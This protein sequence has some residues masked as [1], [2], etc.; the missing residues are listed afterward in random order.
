M[1]KI[2]VGKC[3]WVCLICLVA[4]FMSDTKAQAATPAIYQFQPAYEDGT[5]SYEDMD[6]TGDGT[7]DVIEL[8]YIEESDYE[9]ICK[10][11]V[12]GKQTF[13]EKRSEEP[14]WGE[15]PSWD[16]QLIR[17]KNGK[18]LFDIAC[19]AVDKGNTHSL[20]SYKGGKLTKIYDFQKYYKQYAPIYTVR[21]T[22]VSGNK[23]RAS[24][25]AMFFTTGGI[26]YNINFVY[27]SG[28]VKLATNRYKIQYKDTTNKWT[29]GRTIKVYKKA[30][31][32]K[33]AFTLKK[34]AKVKLNQVIY[35]NN[36]PYI[37]VTRKTGKIKKGYIPCVK[38]YASPRYFE[39]AMVGM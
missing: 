5:Q 3:I 24:A 8:Q 29:V 21:I 15:C 30:G 25:Y 36:K 35:R 19:A 34:G 11:C 37:E 16:V 17:L 23:I 10:I 7:N 13:Y 33:L 6:V 12:N 38:K 18:V 20:Y 2:V 28:K 26:S 4:V 27:K 39:E 31:S 9:G 1:R 14:T 22:G 32:K